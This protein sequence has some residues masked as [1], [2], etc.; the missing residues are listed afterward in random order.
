ME[1]MELEREQKAVL[2]L[3]SPGR[4]P[5]PYTHTAGEKL[6]WTK[7][8]SS[9]LSF[10]VFVSC[11][12]ALSSQPAHY[13]SL[14]FVFLTQSFSLACAHFYT[15]FTPPAKRTGRHS[16]LHLPTNTC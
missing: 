3:C 12:P 4:E 2:K 8:D 6:L 15:P 16:G 1:V 9:T 13:L 11:L 7:S 14:F 10:L 5:H